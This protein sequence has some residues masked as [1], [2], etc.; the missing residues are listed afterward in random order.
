[1]PYSGPK[2]FWKLRIDNGRH[3]F[4]VF[5]TSDKAAGVVAQ[6]ALEA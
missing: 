4:D 5:L 6:F 1:M 3:Y 2:N